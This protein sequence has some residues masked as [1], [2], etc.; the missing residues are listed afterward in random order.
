MS[1][2]CL[3]YVDPNQTVA[4]PYGYIAV[5]GGA[6]IALPL[7][8]A[9]IY[10][11]VDKDG[12]PRDHVLTEDDA[13]LFATRYNRAVLRRSNQKIQRQLE[14][15]RGARLEWRPLVAPGA[16]GIVATF[17]GAVSPGFHF[18]KSLPMSRFVPAFSVP[19]VR[20]VWRRTSRAASMFFGFSSAALRKSRMASLSRPARLSS[21]PR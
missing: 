12:N 16:L 1:A 14:I 17:L 2:D 18:P 11:L 19:P 10:A 5:F 7:L 3:D 6:V 13:R 9:T 15:E 8:G 21:E 4:N 20:I